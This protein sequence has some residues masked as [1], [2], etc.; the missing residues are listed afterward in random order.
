MFWGIMGVY[1]LAEKHYFR[2]PA[3]SFTLYLKLHRPELLCVSYVYT[4]HF[5]YYICII[6]IC[7]YI[8]E[9]LFDPEYFWRGQC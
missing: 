3:A 9:D 5:L 7:I 6:H 2:T 1:D 8:S 4:T